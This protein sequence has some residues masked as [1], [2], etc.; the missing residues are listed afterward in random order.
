M[1]PTTA[2]VAQTSRGLGP[3][4]VQLAQISSPEEN[5][6]E[7]WAQVRYVQGDVTY[8]GRP[9][10]IGDRLQVGEELR[11]GSNSRATLFF[12]SGI[13]VLLLS[14]QTTVQLQ[15][16]ETLKNGARTT[17]LL[18]QR[19]QVRAQVRRFTNPDSSFEIAFRGNDD[20][21]EGGIAGSRGTDYGVAVGPNG[22]TGVSTLSGQVAV[23]T[24]A[25]TV[26]LDAGYS[27]LIVPGQGPT[28][29]RLTAAN[30]ELKLKLLSATE[31][32]KIRVTGA[33]DPLNLVYVNG[34][35][36]E[37]QQNGEFDVVVPLPKNRPLQ[38]LVRTPLGQEQIYELET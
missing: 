18:T 14:E 25:K 30:V 8:Q 16:L 23:M 2:S 5:Q 3:R 13:G 26:L 17:R 15:I 38:V 34:V 12:D 10:K 20:D 28:E 27:S 19:G 36:V 4:E 22:Q 7:R 6:E 35:P 31:P 32:E 37:T 21:I 1:I 11:T 33:G 9:A 29:A 24:P